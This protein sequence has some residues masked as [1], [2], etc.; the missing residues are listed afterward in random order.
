MTSPKQSLIHDQVGSSKMGLI[1]GLVNS[2]AVLALLGLVVYT[3]VIYKRPKITESQERAKIE[4]MMAT[5]EPPAIPGMIHLKPLSVNVR[6]NPGYPH[7]KGPAS[8][9]EKGRL[10]YVALT[11]S[12][13]FKD[14]NKQYQWEAVQDVFMD[15]LIQKLSDSEYHQLTTVQGRYLLRAEIVEIANSLMSDPLVSNSFFSEFL[16]R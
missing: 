11:L 5:Y 8:T 1:M 16:V 10:H 3:R 13:Q 14:T 6:F 9:V 15:K 2:L 4:A 7:T 12:L